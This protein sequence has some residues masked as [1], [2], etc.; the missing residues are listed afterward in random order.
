EGDAKFADIILPACTNFERWDI[1]EWCNAGGY[2][3]HAFEMLNHRVIA[4]QHKCIE[5][6]GESKSDYQIFEGV[7]QRLG[8]SSV[9]T[10]GCSELDWCKRIFDSSDLPSKIS[11]KEFLK[12]GYYV[13]PAEEEDLRAPVAM[14]WFAEG[15]RKDI[16][17][18]FP[19]PSQFADQYGYDL[20]TPSGK[21]E[22][23]PTTLRR[24]EHLS[25]DRPAVN[26]YIPSWEGPQTT[27][28]Y[29]KFPLQMVCTHSRYSFHTHTDNTAFTDQIKDH[30][31][32]VDGYYYWVLR[33]SAKDAR[34]R[35]IESGDLVKI[36]NDRGTV[37]CA[38]DVSPMLGAGTVKGYQSSAKFDLITVDNETVEIGGCLNMLTP[39]RSQTSGTHSMAP[40]S[41][42]VQ[43]EKFDQLE[44]LRNARAA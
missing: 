39:D 2:G 37:I 16:P 43:V 12:R 15:K 24:A 30:R 7:L 18:P 40:N 31:V 25:P 4:L 32:L 11:W 8:L 28:L 27:D 19:L 14:R 38:A 20:Q 42:L 36:Y 13:L 41:T 6:L 9:F 26:R 33:L 29:G 17:E 21:F 34:E 22:F 44:V 5:P 35:G 3:H 1:G 10:E 23:V